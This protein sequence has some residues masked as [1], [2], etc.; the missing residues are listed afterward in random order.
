MQ[1]DVLGMGTRQLRVDADANKS[2]S[3]DVLT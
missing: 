3:R 1:G 2:N